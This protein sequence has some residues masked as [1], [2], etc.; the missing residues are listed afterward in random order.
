MPLHSLGPGSTAAEKGKKRGQ[1][2][3]K[4]ASKEPSG[5]LGSG[6]GATLYPPQNTSLNAES[7]SSLALAFSLISTRS[8]IQ[9]PVNGFLHNQQFLIKGQPCH[10]TKTKLMLLTLRN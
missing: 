9:T 2:G 1:V 7:G 6:K 8:I 10:K 5:I 4:S 3:I